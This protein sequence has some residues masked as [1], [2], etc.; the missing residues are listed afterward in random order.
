[1]F[2]PCPRCGFLVNLIAPRS[3][4]TE[5]RC[6]RC[7]EILTGAQVDGDAVAGATQP[8]APGAARRAPLPAEPMRPAPVRDTARPE[9]DAPPAAPDVAPTS[10]P[11]PPPIAT[12]S[13][14][15]APEPAGHPRR[16]P[17]FVRR[18]RPAPAGAR[19]APLYLAIALLALVLA[20]QLVLAQRHE[21]AADARWR[22]ALAALCGVAGCTLPAWHEPTAFAMLDRAVQPR[23]DAPGVLRARAS[24]RNDARWPQAW[25]TLLLTLS[26][27]DGQPVGVRAFA[28]AEYLGRPPAAPLAPGQ[29]A[30]VQFDIAEPAPGVVA[31][32]FDFR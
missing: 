10:D 8:R 20:L 1:M 23:P 14:E 17:S 16:A 18:A 19:R 27:V 30:T 29:T 2:L 25:P 11:V 4:A 13:R 9:D 5:Q 12:A 7:G 15:P 22:P 31:F 28:P 3:A 6:P 26:D 21:L 32:A 24:F